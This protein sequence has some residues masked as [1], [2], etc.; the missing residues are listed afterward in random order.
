[1]EH[2]TEY[3]LI[4]NNLMYNELYYSNTKRIFKLK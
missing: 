3:S 1:M 4:Y 2:N